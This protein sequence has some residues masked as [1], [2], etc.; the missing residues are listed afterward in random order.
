MN[1]EVLEGL[2][3][4][5]LRAAAPIDVPQTLAIRAAAIPRAAVRHHGTARVRGLPAVWPR[6]AMALVLVVIVVVAAAALTGELGSRGVAGP[7][8]PS[9]PGLAQPSL[10]PGAQHPSKIE[11]GAW[12]SPTVAWLVDG[13]HALRMTEDGGQTWSGP[14]QLNADLRG[15]PTFLDASFGYTMWAQSNTNPVRAVLVL[16][17]DG[18]R[19]WSFVPVGSL[20]AT[21]SDTNSLT[22]HFADQ[23]HGIVLGGLYVQDPIPS[24]QYRNGLRQVACAGWS[25]DDSGRTWA[26]LPNAPCLNHDLWASREVGIVYASADGGPNV[27]TSLDAGRTWHRGTLPGVGTDEYAWPVVFTVAPDGNPRLGY[28]DVTASNSASTARTLIVTETKDGGVTWTEMYRAEVPNL[29]PV[30]AIGPDLWLSSAGGTPGSQPMP[31]PILET[32]D[33]GSTWAPVGSLGTIDGSASS[34]LDRLHGMASGQDDSGCGLPAASPC[35]VDGWFLTNDGG[36][37]WHGVPF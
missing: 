15:N 13:V 31:R 21:R 32:A 33:G 7:S 26:E 1:D 19:T 24:G 37:T 29:G 10:P 27:S 3:R 14:R 17:R 11:D 28:Y 8:I 4:A 5:R 20:P 18:G 22:A 23:T 16:T 12:V 34:W 9:L 6:F 36:V 25:T 30:T 2:L 35:H